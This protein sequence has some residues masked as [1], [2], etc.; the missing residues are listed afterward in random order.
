[1]AALAGVTVAVNVM[2]SGAPAGVLA[3]SVTLSGVAS[4]TTTTVVAEPLTPFVSV[5]VAVTV[6]VPPDV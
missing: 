5:A 3:L 2:D 4:V 1:M 6:N